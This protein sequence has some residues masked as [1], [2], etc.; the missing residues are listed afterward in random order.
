MIE[1]FNQV[2]AQFINLKNRLINIDSQI[3]QKQTDNE[4]IEDANR[5]LIS[6][7][8]SIRQ[9]LKDKLESLANMALKSVFPDKAMNFI[10]TANRSKI[11][12]HYDLYLQTDGNITSLFESS[13]G[14]V[15]EIISI[16]MRISYLRMLKGSLRQTL[17]LDESLKFLDST[18]MPLAIKWL[19]SVSKE[20]GIQII[21]IT[22]IPELIETIDN[23]FNFKL[24]NGK[25]VI[26]KKELLNAT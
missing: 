13:G 11:G 12:L 17:I 7:S 2:K 18:R 26:T 6:F 1:R 16:A 22:H 9:K 20:M 24:I 25:T 5:F 19:K 10:I 21:I 3:E 23:S 15:H 4:L 14:G 8:E